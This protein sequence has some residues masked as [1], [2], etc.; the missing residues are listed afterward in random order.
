MKIFISYRRAETPHEA[1]RIRQQLQS[2]FGPGSVFI[3]RKIPPGEV[4]DKYLA[5]EL[6][7]C[8][9]LVA[10]MGN[11]FFRTRKRPADASDSTD[12]VRWEIETALQLGIPVFPVIVGRREMPRELDLPE[13]LRGF[14]KRQSVHA[15]EPAFETAI[16]E[17]V[18]ALETQRIVSKRGEPSS[19]EASQDP[20]PGTVLSAQGEAHERELSL[21]NFARVSALWACVTMLAVAALGWTIESLAGQSFDPNRIPRYAV[22]GLIYLATT[23][24]LTFAPLCFYKLVNVVRARTHLSVGSIRS[25]ALVASA[26]ATWNT[27]AIFLSLATKPGF[28]YEF[29]GLHLPIWSYL[30]LGLAGT[31]VVAGLAA[32]EVWA[33]DRSSVKPIGMFVFAAHSFNFVVQTSLL[34]VILWSTAEHSVDVFHASMLYLTACMCGCATFAVSW[35]WRESFGVNGRSALVLMAGTLALAWLFL[36]LSAYSAGLG[37]LVL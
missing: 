7:S 16:E 36:T 37:K 32:L 14:T 23:M 12:Y 9:A 35:G 28:K 24:S 2:H 21:P 1:Q 10:V 18:R 25:W 15:R 4:F 26:T 22:L 27:N 13:G 20:G 6:T 19:N 5:S 30:Q 33:A 29:A 3:D 31:L 34:V 8:D 11:D 17:L